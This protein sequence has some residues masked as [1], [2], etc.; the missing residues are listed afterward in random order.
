MCIH[1]VVYVSCVFYF[2][3]NVIISVKVLGVLLGLSKIF[4][5]CLSVLCSLESDWWHEFITAVIQFCFCIR[6]TTYLP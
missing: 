4:V 6:A 2:Y 1:D 3:E 5:A